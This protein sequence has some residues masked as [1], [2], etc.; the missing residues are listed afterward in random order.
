MIYLCD[1]ITIIVRHTRGLM[2]RNIWDIISMRKRGVHVPLQGSICKQKPHS[3]QAFTR[4]S[5][6]GIPRRISPC[7]LVQIGLGCLRIELY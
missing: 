4:V 6:K 2:R 1:T 3:Q 5:N 7:V